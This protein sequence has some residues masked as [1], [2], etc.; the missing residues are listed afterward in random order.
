[1]GQGILQGIR[2]LDLSRSVV[3]QYCSVA[4]ADHGAEV[5]KIESGISADE[6]AELNRGKHSVVLTLETEESRQEFLKMVATADVLVESFGDNEMERLGL[7]FEALAEVKAS[8]VYARLDVSES[9]V[10]SDELA[11]QRAS[12]GIL[13]ALRQAEATG[14]GQVI[15]CSVGAVQFSN[16]PSISAKPAPEPGQDTDRYLSE[17]PVDPPSDADKLAL[18]NVFGAFATGITVV[19][20]RQDDGTPRGFTANSFTSVSLDPPMLLVCIAKSAHSCETFMDAQNFAVNILSEDQKAACGLFA[21]RDPDKFQKADWHAGTA[22]TPILDGSLA[23]I[24]CERKKLVDAGDHIVLLGQVIDHQSTQGKPLG[25]F[26][27]NFF[28]IGL[29]EDLVSAA[30]RNGMVEIGAVLGRG[31]QV[32]LDVSQDGKVTIPKSKAKDQ[33]L[34]GLRNYLEKLGLKSQLDA[35]YS[36]YHNRDTGHHSI[37][38]QGT[39]VGL[40]PPGHKFFNLAEIPIEKVTDKAEQSLLTRYRDEFRHGRFGIYQGDEES[41]VVHRLNVPD[42]IKYST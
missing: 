33:S 16:H 32:L 18:R 4:L 20:A 15:D 8:L 22:G 6:K 29:D 27:G 28:S 36:I 14:V 21:S 42:S 2:V 12:F 38:Y 30:S 37:Y 7:G 13:A 1:M 39:V 11:G 35:L 10:Q 17:M 9:Q 41:G 5:I 24:V 31:Q 23:S 25:Y 34:P 26:Q 19:T 40:A 3:G